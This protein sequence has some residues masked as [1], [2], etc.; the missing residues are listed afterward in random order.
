MPTSSTH[1]ATF[2]GDSSTLMPSVST[3]S[4]EP[5]SEDNERLPCLATLSPAPATTKAV[6]VDTLNVPDASPPVPHVSMSISRSV[7]VCAT[8]GLPWAR[9][10]T[11]FCRIT[12]ANPISS[13]TVSPFM[14]K[15]VRKAAICAL[16]AAPDMTASIAAAASI[17][18]RSRRSTRARTASV[19]IGL[20]MALLSSIPASWSWRSSSPSRPR[21]QP[22][23]L[24]AMVSRTQLLTETRIL[25]VPRL[26]EPGILRVHRGPRQGEG[27][28][29]VGKPERLGQHEIHAMGM[30]VLGRHFDAEAA[31]QNDADG[32]VPVLDG[33]RHLPPGHF[34]HGEVGQHQVEAPRLE[35]A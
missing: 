9:T 20:V 2:A 17:R 5:H 21:V 23:H 7:P 25:R 14:R 34:R 10:V 8:T 15:A 27:V 24:E 11:T 12:C 28:L 1:C 35:P 4:A 6:A 13:S 33:A 31:H 22:T 30:E 19:R 16:V 26:A 32:R 29:D 18:V 3:T